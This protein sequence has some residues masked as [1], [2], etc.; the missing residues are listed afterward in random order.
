MHTESLRRQRWCMPSIWKEFVAHTIDNKTLQTY[1]MCNVRSHFGSRLP[2]LCFGPWPR[3]ESG[4]L[5]QSGWGPLGALGAAFRCLARSL[6]GS[7][8]P[9][10]LRCCCSSLLLLTWSKGEAAR[11]RL[12]VKT[13]SDKTFVKELMCKLRSQNQCVFG[14][15]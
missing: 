6:A 3:D 4:V 7:R 5:G 2:P 12:L 15:R 14:E 8:R 1:Q 10:L 13:E 11:A 9:T